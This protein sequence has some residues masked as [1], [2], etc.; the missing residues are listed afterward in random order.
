MSNETAANDRNDS[1]S[2]PVLHHD[3]GTVQVH[4]FDERPQHRRVR[5]GSEITPPT[6]GFPSDTAR[7]APPPASV[8][9]SSDSACLSRP[10][11]RAEE[12]RADLRVLFDEGDERSRVDGDVA[13]AE[14]LNQSHEAR[15]LT[16]VVGG[17]NVLPLRPEARGGD[18]RHACVDAATIRESAVKSTTRRRAR[19]YCTVSCTIPGT[20][21]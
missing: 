2:A 18:R 4:R 11:G 20:S 9:M 5:R 15:S 12:S 3:D 21:G 13:G 8:P 16:H 7:Q 19:N 14:I 17:V 10:H 1:R 6:N